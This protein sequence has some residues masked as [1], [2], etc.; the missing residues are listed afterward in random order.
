MIKFILGAHKGSEFRPS[1][2]IA[3][4]TKSVAFCGCKRTSNDTGLCDGTHRDD[5]VEW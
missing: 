1:L 3:P 2:F 5:T 4:E